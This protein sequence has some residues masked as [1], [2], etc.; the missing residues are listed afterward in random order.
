MKKIYK[1]YI[2]IILSVIAVA[3]LDNL[4]SDKYF[5][6]RRSLEDVFTDDRE[7]TEEWLAHAY[8]F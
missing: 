1:L 8:S 4:D 3:C 6:D 2:G 7:S 5:K